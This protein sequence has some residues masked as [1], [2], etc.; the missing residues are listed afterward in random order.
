MTLDESSSLAAP[1]PISRRGLLAQA[2]G[3]L[4]AIALA[5]LLH[6]ETGAQPDRRSGR[7]PGAGAHFPAR[8][9]RVVH[10]F[11]TGG[12]SH[13]DTFDWKPE[14]VRSSGKSLTSKGTI[15]TFFGQPGNLM[16]SPWEFRQRGR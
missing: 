2:G 3:G 4:G 16:K 10:I 6:D 15:D 12:V 14:L 11:C 9:K 8:V 7:L 5:C 13:L 1:G